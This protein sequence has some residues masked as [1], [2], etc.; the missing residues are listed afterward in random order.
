MLG[1][2]S[3]ATGPSRGGGHFW[4]LT[5]HPPHIVGALSQLQPCSVGARG[6]WGGAHLAMGRRGS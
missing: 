3:S 6:G 4:A 1:T 2:Q 5:P